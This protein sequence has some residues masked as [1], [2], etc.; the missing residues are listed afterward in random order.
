MRGR[1]LLATENI[2]QIM[3]R[4]S[5][6]VFVPREESQQVV[7]LKVVK[8]D[9]PGKRTMYA[10][11]SFLSDT[12]LL[13]QYSKIRDAVEAAMSGRTQMSTLPNLEGV[14]D[15]CTILLSSPLVRI[16]K[17]PNFSAGRNEVEVRGLHPILVT[18]MAEMYSLAFGYSDPVIFA[19]VNHLG[20]TIRIGETGYVDVWVGK[21][22]RQGSQS[23]VNAI[24]A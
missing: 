7:I 24:A 3:N 18:V 11:V 12:K 21:S 14:K 1:K 17:A 2:R 20:Y 8:K 15:L 22:T 5:R 13:E 10:E 23:N 9:N 4:I 6:L 16:S 19:E